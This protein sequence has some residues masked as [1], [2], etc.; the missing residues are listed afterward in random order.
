[1]VRIWA[2]A[3]LN[4]G[5]PTVSERLDVMAARFITTT[6]ADHAILHCIGELD[7]AT[8][9]ELTTRLRE[10][11]LLHSPRVVVDL[12]SV[13]FMDCGSVTAIEILAR[14]IAPVRGTFVVAPTGVVRRMFAAIDI[15]PLVQVRPTLAEVLAQGRNHLGSQA[16]G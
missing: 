7:L 6:V 2:T 9:S 10:L 13:T 15:D 16:V 8:R 4:N 3:A 14:R 12:A 11:A 5:C 1:V